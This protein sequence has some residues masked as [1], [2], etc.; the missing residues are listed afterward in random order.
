M[1]NFLARSGGISRFESILTP[2]AHQYG[3]EMESQ[4]SNLYDTKNFMQSDRCN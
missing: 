2:S 3:Y 4:Y 1:N